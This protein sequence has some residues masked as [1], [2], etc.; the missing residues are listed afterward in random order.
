MESRQLRAIQAATVADRLFQAFHELSE[1]I[2]VHSNFSQLTRESQSAIS[3]CSFTNLDRQLKLYD[4]AD[5]PQQQDTNY[6]WNL[7]VAEVGDMGGYPV[8][9]WSGLNSAIARMVVCHGRCP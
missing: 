7:A 2:S 6:V 8:S 9:H 5:G 1:Q 3:P 4:Q